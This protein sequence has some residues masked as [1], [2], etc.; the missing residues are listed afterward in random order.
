MWSEKVL[1]GPGEKS[2]VGQIVIPLLVEICPPFPWVP[3]WHL[4]LAGKALEL[5]LMSLPLDPCSPSNFQ[6]FPYFDQHFGLLFVKTGVSDAF[7]LRIHVFRLRIKQG[8]GKSCQNSSHKLVLVHNRLLPK[9]RQK[10]TA[11]DV[12]P[13]ALLVFVSQKL[14][15]CLCHILYLPGLQ[16]LVCC[17]CVHFFIFCFINAAVTFLFQEE[18]QC[19]N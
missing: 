4:L 1:W 5:L 16:V 9:L 10:E 17:V 12:E 18:M 8:V 19:Y 7:R 2:L 6:R 14:D 13:Q 15:S 11:E 3:P